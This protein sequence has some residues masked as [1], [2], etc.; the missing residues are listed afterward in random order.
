MNI[1][2]F[3]YFLT[4]AA[5]ICF[6][7]SCVYVDQNLG[8]NLAPANQIYEVHM[9]EFPL[10]DVKMGFAD[11]LS[12]YSDSRI[13]VGALRDERFG[14]STRSS[15]VPLVPVLDTIDVGIDPIL[16]Y[17]HFTAVR[18]TTSVADFSQQKILQSVNVY[19]LTTVLDSTFIY[20]WDDRYDSF[21][22]SSER[23]T[24][25][26][27]VY[28][29][30][31]SLSF[32]FS[33][34]YAQKVIDIFKEDPNIAG[35]MDEYLKK[36]PG[37]YIT[38]DPPLGYGGRINMFDCPIEVDD[39]GYVTGC[40]ADLE[41]KTKYSASEEYRDTSFLFYFGPEEKTTD[42][43]QYAFNISTHESKDY[44][45]NTDENGL[46][47]CGTE[48]YVEGGAG[49]KPVFNAIEIKTLMLG[50][51]EEQGL[52][53]GDVVINKATIE[54]NY[55]EPNDYDYYYLMPTVL[56]PTCKF[57]Y[58]SDLVKA[59]GTKMRYVYYA[60]LTDS[61][62]SD[63]NQGD[64]N[65]SLD[66]YS[67]DIT[68][69]VQELLKVSDDTLATGKYD[70]WMLILA[71]EMVTTD[72]SN[73]DLAE[74]YE[75][76]AYSSYYSSMYGGYGYGYS[77]DSYSNYYYYMYMAEAYAN[78]SYTNAQNILD[79]DRFYTAVLKGPDLD[80]GPKLKVTYSCVRKD[81]DE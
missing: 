18:D 35:D 38:V 69:H 56:S 66:I 9:A 23:I 12:A 46:V 6:A 39:Y 70:V 53:I 27:P 71:A 65:R 41:I 77:S 55:E 17:F 36:A 72:T 68:H 21:Y 5:V 15:A 13:T 10:T 28:A 8:A 64:I 30:G 2:T 32:D 57:S 50:E 51:L 37:I 24:E 16:L 47:E 54:M 45:T 73:E 44:F 74:Y 59:D 40:Y 49:L 31:D 78:S 58:D 4:F 80:D 52:G 76:L 33:A 79:K 26:V 20:S 75:Y 7:A 14:L 19:E 67:P 29:G 1:K 62:V 11:S 34:K 63:E 22:D 42:T 3:N 60:G 61:S 48:I 25:G 43:D 81:D